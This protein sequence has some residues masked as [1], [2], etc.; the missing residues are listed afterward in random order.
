[1]KK[2]NN[3]KS[4][5]IQQNTSNSNMMQSNL[6]DD[7]RIDTANKLILE[8]QNIA[9]YQHLLNEYSKQEEIITKIHSNYKQSIEKIIPSGGL[10]ALSRISNRPSNVILKS[11]DNSISH[12]SISQK[13]ALLKKNKKQD[14]IKLLAKNEA[15]TDDLIAVRKN[16]A[17]ELRR[18]LK[19]FMN[20]KDLGSGGGG[21]VPDNLELTKLYVWDSLYY[22]RSFFTEIVSEGSVISNCSAIPDWGVIGNYLNYKKDNAGDWEYGAGLLQNQI[23]EVIWVE[24]GNSLCIDVEMTCKISEARIRGKDEWGASG[25]HFVLQNSACVSVGSE[26]K[27]SFLWD[28]EHGKDSWDYLSNT[29]DISFDV[30]G[31]PREE[32]KILRFYFNITK[33]GCYIIWVGLQDIYHCFQNDYQINLTSQNNWHVNQVKVSR[34]PS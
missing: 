32:K 1:M 20:P 29:D 9:D 2:R 10:D 30:K 17:S 4:G 16:F 19:S 25:Y 27:K 28:C 3:S 11:I 8:Q 34:Y 18:K 14:Y 13:N 21:P 33:T 23:G 5:S 24:A 31:I 7:S 12:E 26:T 6:N 22:K 15:S